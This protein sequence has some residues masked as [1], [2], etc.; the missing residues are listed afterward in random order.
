MNAI[1]VALTGAILITFVVM[2]CLDGRS[3]R[4]LKEQGK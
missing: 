3:L 4:R 1:D 2:C